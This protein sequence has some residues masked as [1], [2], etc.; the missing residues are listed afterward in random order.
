MS[1]V[2]ERKNPGTPTE[3]RMRKADGRYLDVESIGVNMV[4]VPGVNG[5]VI[6]TRP[7]TERKRMESELT[8]AK[9]RAELYLDLMSH[10]INNINQIAMGY[11]ELAN[12]RLAIGEADKELVSK[13]LE[14]LKNSSALI[15]NVR[16]LQRIMEGRPKS[17]IID[18]KSMLPG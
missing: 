3:F 11:L 16:K 12:D 15:D 13:P 8:E 14:A 1:H 5:I 6:T 17:D 10:D 2:Y 4:G 7:I 9:E 18:M